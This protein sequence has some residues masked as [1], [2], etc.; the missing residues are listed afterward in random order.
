MPV[1]AHLSKQFYD[2][3][4]D[5]VF[6]ELVNL[7]NVV[8]D[9]SRV[10]LR[11]LNDANYARFD[12]KIDHRLADLRAELE[13]RLRA[14]H[15]DIDQRL[16]GLSAKIEHVEMRLDARIDVVET[17]L[18]ATVERAVG[19]LKTLIERGQKDGVFRRDV[20]VEWHL[21]VLRAIVHAASAELQ[22]GRLTEATVEQTM[23]ATVLAAM[24]SP[25]R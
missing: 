9:T 23:L 2:H 15:S 21:A 4:G 17:R 7:L 12:A 13:R 11:E 19:D 8:N 1:T 14:M 10:E 16:V 22:G 3:F 18:G 25:K 24:A 6:T 5:E 20:P